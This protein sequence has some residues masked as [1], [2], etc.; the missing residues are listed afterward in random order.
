MQFFRF[1][2]SVLYINNKDLLSRQISK[3]LRIGSR[4]KLLT[5]KACKPTD[6]NV[7]ISK[8]KTLSLL[9]LIILCKNNYG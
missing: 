3:P 2:Y 5:N 7:N 1:F 6:R 8:T 9:A 4:K